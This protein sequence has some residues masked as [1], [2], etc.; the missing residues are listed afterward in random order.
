VLKQ[1]WIFGTAV[2]MAL[3]LA[4]LA[5]GLYGPSVEAQKAHGGG[6][7]P[8]GS[9]FPPVCGQM[10]NVSS[11]NVGSSINDLTDVSAL[12][13]NDVWAVGSYFNGSNVSQTLVE[14]WNGA[15]WSVVPSPNTGI[16]DGLNGVFALASNDVWAVGNYYNSISANTLMEHWDGTA[17]SVISSPSP[18]STNIW[19]G[20]VSAL[21]SNDVWAAGSYFN[22]S[23]FQT[24]V[25]HWDGAV[26]SVISS[27]DPGAGTSN[28]LSGVSALASNDVWAVGNY[29]NGSNNGQTLV[30]HWNGAAWSVVPSPNVGASTNELSALSALTINDVWAV[31]YY[32]NGTARQALVEHWNGTAW[33]VVA[34]PNP[35]AGGSWLFGVSALTNNDAW[36][37]GYQYNGTNDQTLVEHWNGNAWNVVTSS[38]LGATAELVGVAAV[39]AGDAWAVGYYD[40]AG[41]SIDQTLAEQYISC[42][43]TPTPT[44][45]ATHA[46]IP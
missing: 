37:V 41:S 12:S 46:A 14:H 39:S 3:A 15:V 24:L 45:S 32:E 30:E 13:N 18:S 23:V 7:V 9:Q 6:A 42:P 19:L 27:P 35:G 16:G 36:A 40:N 26:W 33:S 28:Y 2:A 20:G 34:S 43:P 1:A 8:A 25:E 10:N 21:A 44:A 31:G 17:W 29:I 5:L 4:L 11:P 22:G 38:N